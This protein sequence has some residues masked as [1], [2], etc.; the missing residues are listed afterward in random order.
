MALKQLGTSACLA[1]PHFTNQ[2]FPLLGKYSR[3][4]NLGLIEVFPQRDSRQVNTRDDVLLR[5]T[6]NNK[7][8]TI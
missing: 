5:W 2:Q 6:R 3:S 1:L 8:F 4:F 7:L